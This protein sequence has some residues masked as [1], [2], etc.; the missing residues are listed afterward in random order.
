MAPKYSIQY[1]EKTTGYLDI[2][3]GPKWDYIPITRTYV[4]NFLAIHSLD[5]KNISQIE[6]AASELLENAVKYSSKDGIRMMIHKNEKNKEIILR[7]Y[8][9][10]EEE[11]AQA[12]IKKITAMNSANPLD[13]YIKCIRESKKHKEQKNSAGVGLARI[14]HEGEAKITPTYDKESGILEIAAILKYI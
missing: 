13:H 11:G 4:E 1:E 12:V 2:T 9:F 14:Y 5:K 10:S 3:F 6:M 7:I 8:N